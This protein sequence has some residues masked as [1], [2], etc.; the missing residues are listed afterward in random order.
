MRYYINISVVGNN[1]KYMFTSPY[2]DHVSEQ[3]FEKPTEYK[4]M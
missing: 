2:Q 1:L 3:H 4:M